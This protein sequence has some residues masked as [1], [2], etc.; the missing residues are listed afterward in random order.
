MVNNILPMR[1]GEFVRAYFLGTKHNISKTTVLVTVFVERI[2]DAVVL[3]GFLLVIISLNAQTFLT[4]LT[5]QYLTLG[6]S[7]LIGV[8]L[9]MFV[10]MVYSAHNPS[11]N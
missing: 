10:L 9:I 5:Q 1:I 6:F 8:F 2:L 11:F 4:G 3:I 7:I